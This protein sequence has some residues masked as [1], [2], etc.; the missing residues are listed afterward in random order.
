M[1]FFSEAES[2]SLRLVRMSL[3]LVGGDDEFTPQPELPA[4][5]ADFLLDVLKEIRLRTH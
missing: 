1:A 3:H 5:N 2:A 4:G